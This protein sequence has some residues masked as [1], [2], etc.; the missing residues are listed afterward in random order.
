MTY[1]KAEVVFDV[2]N[3]MDRNL[4]DVLVRRVR[5]LF[6]DA[7]AAIDIEEEVD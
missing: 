2:R 5:V 6:L 7:S 4:E 3:E 1:T